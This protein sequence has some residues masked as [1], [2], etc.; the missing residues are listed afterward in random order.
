M[1]AV[2]VVRAAEVR[3]MADLAQTRRHLSGIGNLILAAAAVATT[4]LMLF[5][6]QLIGWFT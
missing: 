5:P 2:G 6:T 3:R 1:R 4:A